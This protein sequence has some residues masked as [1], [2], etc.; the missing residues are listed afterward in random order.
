[1]TQPPS[2]WDPNAGQQS[3]PGE[4]QP[5]QYGQYGQQPPSNPTTGPQSYP[6]SAPQPAHGSGYQQPYGQQH[7]YGGSGYGGG[8]VEKPGA[9]TGAAVLGFIQA[10][11]TIIS[12]ALLFIGLAGGSD[13][14]ADF[15]VV[16]VAQL[17]GIVLLIFGSVQLMSG[18]KRSLYLIAVLLQLALSLYWLL[19]VLIGISGIDVAGVGEAVGV[20]IVVV[21]VFTIMPLI[22]LIL[23]LGSSVTRYLASRSGRR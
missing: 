5:G 3:A 2:S 18:L 22:G 11:L 1:M 8:P 13:A 17:A 16:A 20:W 23:A 4:G 6:Q 19:R 15:W 10:G 21:A 7:G 9:V 12:T 14:P